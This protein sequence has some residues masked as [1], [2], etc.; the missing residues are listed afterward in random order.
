MLLNKTFK[1][2]FVAENSINWKEVTVRVMEK[3]WMVK[4]LWIMFRICEG[5]EHLEAKY[6]LKCKA[7]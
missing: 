5:E 1:A 6:F 7:S 2:E 4:R 3:S